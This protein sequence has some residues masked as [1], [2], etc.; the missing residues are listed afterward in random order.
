MPRRGKHAWQDGE[1]HTRSPDGW[2]ARLIT[3][4]SRAP[5]S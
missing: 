4:S 2:F 5:T 3:A 1:N